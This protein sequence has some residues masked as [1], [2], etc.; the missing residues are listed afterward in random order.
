MVL[1]DGPNDQLFHVDSLGGHNRLPDRATI[2]T[3][4]QQQAYT[5]QQ[6]QQQ[7]QAYTTHHAELD[8]AI[9]V[10]RALLISTWLLLLRLDAIIS[11]SGH[12]Q[13]IILDPS[14]ESSISPYLLTIYAAN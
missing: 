3:I 7:Q 13:Q 14:H 6:Q 2:Y 5:T 8:H 12:S 10:S 9:P 11:E 4:P 1:H